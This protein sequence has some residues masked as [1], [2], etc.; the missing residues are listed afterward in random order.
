MSSQL[1]QF[2]KGKKVVVTGHT[3]FKGAWLTL[4]LLEL[5]ATVIGISLQEE[6]DG[7]FDKLNISQEIHHEI[8]DIRDESKIN[9]ILKKHQPD[10]VFHLA[11]QSLVRYSYTHP[12]ESFSTNVI[13]TANVLFHAINIPSVKAIVNIT[14]DKV[15]ENQ[16][17]IYGYREN[18]RLGGYDPYSASKACAE[19][20]SASLRQSFQNGHCIATVRAGNVIGGG[21]WALDRIIPDCVRALSKQE[22][23]VLRYPNAIRPWQHV[24]EPLSGYLWLALHL[25]D[26]NE[27]YA[28]AWNFGPGI[29]DSIPVVDITKKAV[30]LWGNGNYRIENADYHET[31]RLFL[32]ITKILTKLGWK[33]SLSIDQAMEMTIGW[34]KNAIQ[35]PQFNTREFTANQIKHFHQNAQE[36][37]ISWA[38]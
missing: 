19:L 25:Y 22:T 7:F 30:A 15:Y 5:G 6:K 23:I 33:P 11:A 16:E 36:K 32:D 9:S 3:G 17:W 31:S 37:N 21:D 28:Q 26:N 18:D 4:W 10:I 27:E 38:L 12:L 14:T 20:V 2:F 1:Y 13:G 24:L 8:A 34:Y 29:A 35:D